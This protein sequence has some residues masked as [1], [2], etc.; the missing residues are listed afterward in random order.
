MRFV[1]V[2]LAALFVPTLAF[3]Q[4]ACPPQEPLIVAQGTAIRVCFEE[5]A[6]SMDLE[7]GGTVVSISGPFAAGTHPEQITI[8]TCSDTTLRA[9]AV[10][11]AGVGEWGGDVAGTFR[12]CAA[13]V[14]LPGS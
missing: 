3:A 2:I 12:P 7:V 1:L 13:P 11:A 4:S 14:L 6:A 9:R 8:E 5:P 10:N